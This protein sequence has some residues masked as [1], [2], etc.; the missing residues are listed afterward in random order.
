M[1]FGYNWLREF[2]AI[3][4]GPA[5]LAERLSM[6]GFPVRSVEEVGPRFPGILVGEVLEVGKHPRAD[7]L[8]LCRVSIGESVLSIVC[9]ATNVKSRMKVP[10]ACIGARLPNGTKVERA[11]IRGESSEG[12]LCSGAELGLSEDASGILAL[13]EGSVPGR[14]LDEELGGCETVI[15]IEVGHNRPDC[16]SVFGV[17][18]E[19]SALT[20]ARLTLPEFDVSAGPASADEAVAVA[21]ETASDCPRYCG[22]VVTGLKVKASPPWLR[23]RLEIAGFRSLGSVVDATNYCLAT[24]G[25]PIHAFDL[26]RQKRKSILVRR[27]RP[28]ESLVTLD[29]VRRLLGPDVL[30][31]TDSGE[32][33]ALAGLMGGEA[34]EVTDSSGRVFLESA[35]FEPAA[36]KSGSKRLG[37]ETEASLRF[38]RGVD[39]GM[40]RW[41]VEYVGSLMASIAGGARSGSVVDYYP[42]KLPEKRVKIDPARVANLLGGSV[43]ADFMKESLGR[44]GFGWHEGREGVEVGVPSFR[45]DIGE[46]VDVTEEVARSFG[47]DRFAERAANLSW[48]PGAD[49]EVELFLD[50]CRESLVTLGLT[51]A[52]T[53]TLVDPK[54][55]VMFGK[56]S[57]EL[58]CLSNPASL[59]ESVLRPSLLVSLLGAVSLNL[60]RGAQNLRLFEIGKTYGLGVDG[61]SV[62]TTC[63]AGVLVGCRR[64]S[65]WQEPAPAECDFFDL[66]GTVESFL[67][68]LNIDNCEVLCYDGPI[69]E[70]EASGSICCNGK[71]LGLFGMASRQLLRAFEIERD[72]YV[73]ELDAEALRAFS[74]G[75]QVFVEP[76]RFPPVKRDL[77]AVVDEA[78]PQAQV[79]GLIEKLGGS[80]LRR[81]RLFDLYRG[82]AIGGE[83]K[84]LAYSL[85]FQSDERTL[86]DSE[87]DEAMDRI[88]RGLIANGARIRGRLSKAD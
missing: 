57:D 8:V 86:S 79:A 47:Y 65:S 25:Q 26:D 16:L 11:V 23:S 22:M 63:A 69:A 4:M 59:E 60:R 74:S 28:G 15:E 50:R 67:G 82:E 46:E 9:G 33:V 18:R 49:E 87:V 35:Y 44:L 68:K 3:D 80:Y 6:L 37:L 30:V 29:G 61:G 5:A 24:F 58:V 55:A 34:T 45:H 88:I 78:L 73:F 72:V 51:E 53:R 64:P 39:P 38:S 54:K 19:V 31:I 21:V 70:K 32:P 41:C 84:S 1:K 10:V 27:G 56:D 75:R 17:A 13:S 66:R 83:E 81:L 48:V 42:Q 62:E 12:M 76:S 77:A 71:L 85:S 40:V 36:V 52:L 14:K 7:R 2:V 20:G 43:S